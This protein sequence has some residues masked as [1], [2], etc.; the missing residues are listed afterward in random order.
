MTKKQIIITIL[1]GC[2]TGGL[3]ASAGIWANDPGLLAIFTGA[4][5]LVTALVG[6]LGVDR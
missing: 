5:A 1:G 6:Y 4:T 3:T 2:I